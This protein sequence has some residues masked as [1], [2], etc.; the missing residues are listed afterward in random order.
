MT[1]FDDRT[2]V[3]LSDVPSEAIELLQQCGSMQRPH[4]GRT[5]FHHLVG[6]YELLR[7]WG[8]SSWICLGGLFHSIYG[9]NAFPLLSLSSAQRGRLQAVIGLEAEM[10]AWLFCNIDRPAAITRTSKRIG[11]IAEARVL[12]DRRRDL[13][14][15]PQHIEVSW[16]QWAAL[17]EI[18]SA[19]LI[20]QKLW[21]L[22]LRDLYCAAIDRPASSPMVSP[23][24][25][26]A[27]REGFASA[28]KVPDAEGHP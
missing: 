14:V 7:S 4:S 23:K 9:T 1:R 11:A 25:M 17:A 28:M 19:N 24:A 27:L 15:L 22:P 20:E 13:V 10:L 26:R 18:E 6:T 16:G 21:S 3:D 5:L 12:L 8:N 2:T